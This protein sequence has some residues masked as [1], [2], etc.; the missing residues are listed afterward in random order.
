M[1]TLSRILD[2]RSVRKFKPEKLSHEVIEQIVEHAKFAP[3]WANTKTARFI[4]VESEETKRRIA[5]LT[6]SNREIIEKAPDLFIITAVRGRSGQERDGTLYNHTSDE[7]TMF[8]CGLAA[9]TLCLA[10]A[11]LG[12]GTV[13]MGGYRQP[14]ISELLNLPEDQMLVALIPAGKPD[15]TPVAPRRKA[16]D[17]ILQII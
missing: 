2:R 16:L 15:E 12:V 8:D 5:E 3:S 11:E 13:I 6:D 4:C 17:E 10:A 7:W 9:Q 14:E 1:D